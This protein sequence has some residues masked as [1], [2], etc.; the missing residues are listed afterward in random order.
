M[1]DTLMHID[2]E[3]FIA[4]HNGMQ[5]DWLDPMMLT[6][7]NSRTW[8]PL[9][10]VFVGWSFYRFRWRAFYIIAAAALIVLFADQFASSL[11]K[12]W[13]Q[14]LRPCHDP[15]LVTHI[16]HII[17]CGG[18]YGF[19]SSHASNHF[20]LAVIFS[21][22]FRKAWNSNWVT[23]IFMLWATL[24][25]FAQVYVAKHFPG[26][27]IVGGLSGLLIGIIVVQLMQR[28]L[29]KNFQ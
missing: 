5:A 8:I 22:V 26:D 21:W 24:I 7:R 27:V 4:I 15:E 23:T 19:V 29:F 2:R 18:R 1:I 17:D 12:P 11:M 25:A 3:L 10:I 20:G 6:L 9:Y 16:R 28:Y 14:R 13:V